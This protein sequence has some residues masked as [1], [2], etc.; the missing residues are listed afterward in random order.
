MSVDELVAGRARRRRRRVS[1]SAILAIAVAAVFVLSLMVGNTF[2]GLGVVLDVLSGT[3]TSGAS[4]TVGELRMPRAT[5][6]LLAGLSFGAA[7][8]TFQ[9]MLRNPLASPDVIGISGGAS[10]A[11]VVGLVSL[12]LSGS[13]VSLMA[14]AGGLGT[15]LGMYVLASRGG[16]VG[17]RLVLV[18]IGLAAMLQS[19]VAYV[20]SRAAAWDLQAAMQWLTGSLNG[21]TWD[22]VTLLG[23]AVGIAGSALLGASRSLD[24]VRLG[25]DTAASLGLRVHVTRVHLLLAA[26]VLLAFATAA[27]G[28]ISFVAFMSGP[29][30]S[31]LVGPGASLVVPAAL[32]GALLVLV[33]DLVG[34]N[35]FE[36][37]YPVGVVTGVL[38]APYLI[39]LLIAMNRTGASL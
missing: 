12:G 7:G 2:H 17:G 14:L 38:G 4:F 29:I 22:R 31:R 27:A 39:S 11:A 3:D 10:A 23:L 28:P 25:D 21:A 36:H 30:A 26:V 15:A 1:V 32:V 24:V 5:L 20:L 6:G 18:G 34:Q 9:T 19:I 35:V 13:A 8:V 16:F 33:A 37:R